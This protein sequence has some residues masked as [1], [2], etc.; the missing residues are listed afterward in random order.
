MALWLAINL[1]VSL[2]GGAAAMAAAPGDSDGDG[3]VDLEDFQDVIACWLGPGI[4]TD[5]SPPCDGAD[6]DFDLDVDLKDLDAFQRCFSGADL[7]ADPDC[8]SHTAAI[9][10]GCLRIVGTAASTDLSFRLRP[11]VPA[12]LDVDIGDD[13]SVEVSFARP[14]F[15]CIEVYA[16]GGNDLVR[17]DETHGAFTDTE[18]TTI[19]GGDGSDTLLGGIGGEIFIGGD[20]ADVVQM[21][22]GND[23]FIWNPDDDTDVV[24]GADGIDTVE[25][26]GG[27]GAEDF[28]V[29][30]NGARVRFDRI[31]PAPFALDIGTSENLVL[32]ANGGNDTLACTGNLAALIKITADGGLGEDTLLGSNGIDILLGGDNDDFIDGQQGNDVAFLGAGDDTFQ[33]DPGDG[34]D[35]VEGQAGHDTLL[36]NGSAGA[37]TFDASANGGRLR[38]FRNLGN[39]VMDCDDVEKLDVNALGNTDTVTVNDLAGTDVT[40]VNVNLAGTIGGGTGDGQPDS[41]IVTGTNGDDVALVEGDTGGT[42]VLGLTAQVNITGAEAAND[43]VTINA[44]AGHDVVDASGLVAGAIQ[45]TVSGG[46]G[47]DILARR[48]WKRHARGRR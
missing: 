16:R 18:E 29:T 24:D 30:A 19:H 14:L 25:V 1:I 7:P 21:G 4:P 32:N 47:D 37:E 23:R 35:T 10:E 12:I 46:A 48:R 40:E 9:V 26:N 41:V 28:T 33:W 31:N 2:T 20:G 38:F 27:G 8:V 11:G 45:L 17:I 15:D 44:L 36:F 3:D 34:S 43:R 22:L 39:I 13:G 42:S 5:V 6:F